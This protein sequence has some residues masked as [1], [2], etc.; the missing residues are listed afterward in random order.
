MN[1]ENFM[2]WALV[3]GLTFGLTF[4]LIKLILNLTQRKKKPKA[5]QTNK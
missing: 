2:A 5:E 4:G 3:F 1:A